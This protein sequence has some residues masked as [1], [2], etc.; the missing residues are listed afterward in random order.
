M[1]SQESYLII[2]MKSKLSLKVQFSIFL[3]LKMIRLVI[4][5]RYAVMGSLHGLKERPIA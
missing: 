1:I 4:C 5:V 3:V 2:T